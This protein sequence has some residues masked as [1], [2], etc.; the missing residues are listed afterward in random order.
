[1]YKRQGENITEENFETIRE[2]KEAEEADDTERVQELRAEL[3]EDGVKLPGK[4]KGK[5]KHKG[6][7]KGEK[8]ERGERKAEV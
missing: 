8:G 3:K 2:L 6:G 5:G 7:K 1:M 4:K